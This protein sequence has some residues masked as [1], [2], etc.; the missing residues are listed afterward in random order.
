M[1]GKAFPD[2]ELVLK[3]FGKTVEARPY[4]VIV[5]KRPASVLPLCVVY[6][7]L[8]DHGFHLFF[9][10]A[11]EYNRAVQFSVS[12]S[13]VDGICAVTGDGECVIVC[14]QD[15][16]FHLF[17]IDAEEYNRAVQFSVSTSIV[18]GICAV[19]GDGECVIVCQQYDLQVAYLP[20]PNGYACNLFSDLCTR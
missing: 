17:F 18:D 12:T 13:I 7:G 20:N 3:A 19:T 11:E 14:L 16:G 4:E 15:H 1:V 9:I 10:D 6:E 8:Q 5:A 2:P